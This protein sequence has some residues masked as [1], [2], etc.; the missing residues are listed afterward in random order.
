[1]ISSESNDSHGSRAGFRHSAAFRKSM[2]F[3]CV[4]NHRPS[5][6]ATKHLPPATSSARSAKWHMLR[7]PS[8]RVPARSEPC[9]TTTAALC[10]HT[11]TVAIPQTLRASRRV[12]DCRSSGHTQRGP[13]PVA[14]V[15]RQ[16]RTTGPI[17]TKPSARKPPGPSQQ[18][19][20][21]LGSPARK[22]CG[23]VDGVTGKLFQCNPFHPHRTPAPSSAT[24]VHA[25]DGHTV[26]APF[27]SFNAARS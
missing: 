18:R 25:G 11:L 3:R 12:R 16:Q 26:A 23:Q 5:C 15:S 21:A 24:R 1:V 2:S 9:I 4:T 7:Y 14:A 13:S 8:R 27:L 19:P 17:S 10:R 6:P 22:E 20:I